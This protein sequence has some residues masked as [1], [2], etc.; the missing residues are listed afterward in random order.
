M[1]LKEMTIVDVR[2]QMVLRAL[3]GKHTVTEIAEM[4]AVS[5]PTVRQWRER[6]RAL[7]RAG[8]QDR[9]HVPHRCPHRTERHIEQLTHAGSLIFVIECLHQ[10]DMTG[11]GGRSA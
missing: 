9:S 2:E 5:R 11:F 8:L 1:P 4:F 7:G 3:D 10:R 6:Y